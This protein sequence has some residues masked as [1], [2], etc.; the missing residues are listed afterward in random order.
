MQ[1]EN[2][3][4]LLSWN[5]T[6]HNRNEGVLLKKSQL[7][8]LSVKSLQTTNFLSKLSLPFL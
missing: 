8:Q 7:S 6:L 1:H 2:A 4:P 3:A 5:S